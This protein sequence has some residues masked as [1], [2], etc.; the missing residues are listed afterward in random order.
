MKMDIFV[1]KHNNVLAENRLLK[2]IIVVI[3]TVVLINTYLLYSYLNTSRTVVVP[4][5]INSKLE[6]YGN[7]AS[8]AYYKEFTRYIMAL[9]LNYTPATIRDQ[10]GELLTLF[11]PSVYG[12]AEEVFYDL[13][14]KVENARV[15]SMFFLSKI[16]VQ[17]NEIHAFGIRRVYSLTGEMV[18]D[19]Q[20][21]YIIRFKMDNGRFYLTDIPKKVGGEEKGGK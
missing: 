11:I 18:Q 19:K 21:E 14:D 15:S 12:K 1:S 6:I 9:R 10:L 20:E 2:F 8:E 5:K 13:A 17:G 7:K 4:P 16:E 3:G